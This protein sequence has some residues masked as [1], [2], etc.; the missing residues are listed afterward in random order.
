MKLSLVLIILIINFN[1]F[2]ASCC[3]GG[4]GLPT[5]ITGDFRA[6][7]GLSISSSTIIA[8]TYDSN[9]PV[10]YNDNKE[11]KSKTT[12]LNAAYLFDNYIQIGIDSSYTE[13]IH[14]ENTLQEENK[15]IGDTSLAITNEFL[16]E[17]F[18]SRWIPRGFVFFKQTFPTGHSNFETITKTNS[19]VTGK[20]VYSSSIGIA[21]FK[22]IDNFDV[23]IMTEA[24]H[25]FKQEFDNNITVKDSNGLSAAL[26]IGHSPK[27][28]NF[29]YGLDIAPFY[30]SKK[31]I[32]NNTTITNTSSEY[33]WNTGLSLSY[34]I[35]DYSLS[36]SYVDQTILGPTKNTTLSRTINLTI[37]KRWSL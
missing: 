11:Y 5:L 14:K 33:Y 9:T 25:N 32:I 19:D 29:R 23:L 6:Q 35:S 17:R 2:A 37:Q 7:I 4:A 28:S 13:K 31:E 20:G 8:R 18:Y 3:G 22:I 27:K 15:N 12:K 26:S 34:L 16:P 36:T 30:E 10:F 24:H 1:N 21:F